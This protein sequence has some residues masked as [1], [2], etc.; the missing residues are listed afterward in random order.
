MDEFDF[1]RERLAPLARGAPGARGLSDDAATLAPPAGC[2]LVVTADALVAGVHFRQADP[3]DGVAAKA[4]RVNLSDLAAKG[5]DP[6]GYLLSI[7]WPRDCPRTDM[8]RFVAGLA[9]DQ[10]RYGVSLLGGDTTSGPGPLVIAITAFG[11]VPEGRMVTRAGARPGDAVFVTG[12][13]G[14]AGLGLRA[15][16]HELTRVSAPDRVALERRYLAPEPRVDAARALRDL[17]HAAIDVSDGLVA[18]AGHI[19]QTSGAR[20]VIEAL[21]IPLSAAARAWLGAEPDKAAAMSKLATSGDDYEILFCAP[22]EAGAEVA[23]R[24]GVP[25][26]RIGRVE[27]GQGVAL[28]GPGGAPI[29]VARGGFTHF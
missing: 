5:A 10:A 19:A 21:S 22:P 11:S 25:V 13:V 4:L 6:I 23:R 16:G 1:I 3:L 17:A 2:E 14:D 7:V 12:T 8:E 26:T 28:L 27:A 24:S 9:D 18:D 20:L 15:L 29:P